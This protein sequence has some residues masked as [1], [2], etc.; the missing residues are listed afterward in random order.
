M[1]CR[2][3]SS[4]QASLQHSILPNNLLPN[5]FDDESYPGNCEGNQDK[6]QD[7]EGEVFADERNGSE[8]VTT[9]T[10]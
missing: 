9:T 8:E 4:K 2:A 10:T 1:K 3:N 6:E 5:Q 7:E